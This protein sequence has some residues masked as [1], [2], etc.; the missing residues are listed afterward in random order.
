MRG[1][2]GGGGSTFPE[3]KLPRPML[4]TKDF[5]FSFS[6]LKTAVLYLIKKIGKLD[7]KT[8]KEIAREFEDAVVETLVHKTLSA[9]SKYKAKT[10]IVAGGVAANNHLQNTLAEKIKKEKLKIKTH[11]PRKDLA[12]DNSLMIGIAGYF[13]YM[14]AGKKVPRRKIKAEGGLSL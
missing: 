11:F 2:G 14:R 1:A 12:T 7:N 5:D 4:H 13:S 6:G 10:L 8:K 3:I 9:V